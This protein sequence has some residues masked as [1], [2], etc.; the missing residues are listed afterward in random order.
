MVISNMLIMQILRNFKEK[1][2]NLKAVSLLIFLAIY[3]QLDH[4]NKAKL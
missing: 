2:L 1:I 3:L 4:Q